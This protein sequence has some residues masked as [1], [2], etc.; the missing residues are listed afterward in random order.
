MTLK[1]VIEEVDR[2]KPNAFTNDEKT[3][4]VANCEIQVA[5]EIFGVDAPEY[6]WTGDQNTELLLKAPF[7]DVYILYVMAQID[8]R[9]GDYGRYNNELSQFDQRFTD[10][11]AWNLRRHKPRRRWFRWFP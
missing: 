3:Q 10:A 8:F 11:Q 1:Q 2:Q 4:F 5:E 9:N 7:E 6:D